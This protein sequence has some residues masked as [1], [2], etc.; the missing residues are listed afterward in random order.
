MEIKLNKKEVGDLLIQSG[1]IS[2]DYTVVRMSRSPGSID[3]LKI[4][5]EKNE[6]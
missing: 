5:I 2:A 6:R 1:M 3:N 4:F